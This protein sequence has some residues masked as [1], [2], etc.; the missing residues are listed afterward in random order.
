ML[1]ETKSERRRNLPDVI[2][3]T[4]VLRLAGRGVQPRICSGESHGLVT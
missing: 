2:A 1:L 4:A 3:P